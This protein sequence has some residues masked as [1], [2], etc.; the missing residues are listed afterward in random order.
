[1]VLVVFVLVMVV[2]LVLVALAGVFMVF[3]YHR[4]VCFLL[5][6]YEVPGATGLQKHA[7]QKLFLLNI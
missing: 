4:L 3:V 2:M 5:Q 7:S 6:R 1:M